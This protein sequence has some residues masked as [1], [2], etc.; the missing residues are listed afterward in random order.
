MSTPWFDP[1]QFGIWFGVL[2]G[3]VGGSLAGVLGAV[4]GTLAPQGRG[5]VWVLG[6]MRAFLGMGLA[7]AA[8]GLVALVCGQP[9]G[10]WFWP[11]F[12]GADCAVLF[13][14]LTPVVRRRYAEAE[15][16]R[17]EAEALRRG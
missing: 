15:E 4:A 13:G 5:R 8:L 3:G 11:L 6:A 2:V 10:I 9:F 12:V 14:F 1:N 7:L 17:L 16:R